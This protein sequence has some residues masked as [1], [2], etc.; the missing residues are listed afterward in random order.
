MKGYDKIEPPPKL[1]RKVSQEKT[2]KSEDQCWVQVPDRP[3]G[4]EVN[5][6]TGMWR[7]VKETAA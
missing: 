2:E 4:I 5:T 6:K 7:N 1:G 3:R